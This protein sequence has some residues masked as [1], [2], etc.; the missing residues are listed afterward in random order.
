MPPQLTLINGALA[1]VEYENGQG[2]IEIT[3]RY[4]TGKELYE[5]Q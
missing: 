2:K 3:M 4:G 1:K 5:K